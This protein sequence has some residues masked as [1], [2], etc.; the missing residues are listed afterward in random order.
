MPRIAL[1]RGRDINTTRD[2]GAGMTWSPN[3]DECAQIRDAAV[4][5]AVRTV[6]FSDSSV[7]GCPDIT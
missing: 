3:L 2:D 1:M 4:I 6:V 7:N 5:H